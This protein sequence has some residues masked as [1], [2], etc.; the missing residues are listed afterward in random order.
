MKYD[1]AF[2]EVFAEEEAL[3]KRYLPAGYRY[4]FT[5][6]SIQDTDTDELPAPV[7]STRTQSVIPEK[8]GD[9]L[10]AIF[11]RSTG[12][13]HLN[14]FFRRI[15]HPIPAGYLP[16]Y[17]ARAVAEQAFLL[18]L[19]LLRKI[20]LQRQAVRH[21]SRDGLSGSELRGKSL[22]II[23][24]GNIGSEIARVG[25][26]MDMPLLGVDLVKRAEITGAYGLEYVDLPQAISQARIVVCALPLT[27][28]TNRMLDYKALSGIPPE[29]SLINISRG[30]ITPPEDLLRLLEENKLSG[31]GIDVYDQESVLGSYLRG[32]T[33]P[34]DLTDEQNHI[35]LANRKLLEHPQVIATPH[36]AFNTRESTDRKSRKTAQNIEAFL[37]Q[38]KFLTP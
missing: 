38:G 4:F 3:L 21:F 32:E 30:E 11:T 13:D 14:I 20:D 2:Y 23:G 36:N 28:K 27:D 25:H 33:S 22:S 7:I 1:V 35:L 29:A 19:M 26:G 10:S 17:A 24:V 6:K 15:S 9:T 12:F 16:K 8:W 37:T 31:V 18:M 5:S 34:A